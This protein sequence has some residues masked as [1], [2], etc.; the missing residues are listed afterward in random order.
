MLVYEKVKA[1]MT[2]HGIKQNA[3]AVKCDLSASTFNAIMNG[4][5]KMYAEDL[6]NICYALEVSPEIFIDYRKT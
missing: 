3:I 4:K 6:R 1:Y 2:E 5:R